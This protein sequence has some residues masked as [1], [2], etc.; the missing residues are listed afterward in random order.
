METR[1]LGTQGLEVSALGL[2]CMGMSEFYGR[3]D[4]G[5]AIATIQ[6]RAR[7]RSHLPRHGRHVRLGRERAARR[8]GDRGPARGR[9]AGDE[10]RQRPRSER[11]VPRHQRQPRRTS[12]PPARH[13]CSDS[14]SRRSTSTTSTGSTCRRR[15]RR[16]SARWPSSCR[17]G[18]CATSAS[19]R[20]RRTTIRRAH[21]VHP[22]SALQSEYS[23]WTRDPEAEVAAD[24]A[25]ARDRLR[26]LQPARPRLP[27][28]PDPLGRRPR[29]DGLPATRPSLPGGEPAPEPRA[30]RGGRG[31]GRGEGRDTV[32]GRARLGAD[33]RR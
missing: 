19:P 12:A 33:A 10:V 23:L 7:A 14:A 17:R 18:R 4:E 26:R 32:A 30:R 16:P 31:A 25:R 29:R 13:R 27:L 21:A 5:E 9:R 20:R 6:A 28:R 24:G 3:A 8:Q 1:I 2:G 22:I 15:S 11:R